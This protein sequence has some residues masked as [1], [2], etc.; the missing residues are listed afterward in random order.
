M[1]VI[2]LAVLLLSS[3]NWKD[4][5]EEASLRVGRGADK[6]FTK[7]QKD[8]DVA[9]AKPE[10]T[11]TVLK[12]ESSDLGSDFE[13]A[14]R[15]LLTKKQAKKLEQKGLIRTFV[16]KQVLGTFVTA[17]AKNKLKDYQCTQYVVLKKATSLL[18]G[19]CGG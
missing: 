12:K 1:R 5:R 11:L 15:S 7:L 14:F 6:F 8:S 17:F 18:D 3:C 19:V 10:C 4:V 2:L 13:N 16:C 9:T